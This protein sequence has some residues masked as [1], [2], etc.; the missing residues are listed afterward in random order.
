[1]GF[2]VS[3][4]CMVEASMRCEC[5]LEWASYVM[6]ISA[7]DKTCHRHG[8][9][10]MGTS[11][12]PWSLSQSTL[13]GTATLGSRGGT[14]GPDEWHGGCMPPTLYIRLES[15]AERLL[16][17][18]G[19]QGDLAGWQHLD[20]RT[21][22]TTPTSPLHHHKFRSLPDCLTASTMFHLYPRHPS[23]ALLIS[24]HAVYNNCPPLVGEQPHVL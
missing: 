10:R 18:S 4:V 14:G 2:W 6:G 21:H 5:D 7:V 9:A 17:T 22:T 11:L 8:E 15:M 19:D 13:S 20:S 23:I 1:M 16:G 24:S 12:T 3:R